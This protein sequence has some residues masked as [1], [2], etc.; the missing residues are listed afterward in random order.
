MHWAAKLNHVNMKY[1]ISSPKSKSIQRRSIS[2]E[3]LILI[4]TRCVHVFIHLI[5]SRSYHFP[6][7][8]EQARLD[9]PASRTAYVHVK[10][11]HKLSEHLPLQPCE[12][13]QRY[14]MYNMPLP[15]RSNLN[16]K[17]QKET[18]QPLQNRALR[19]LDGSQKAT[20]PKIQRYLRGLKWER[21]KEFMSRFFQSYLE[22]A[23]LGTFRRTGI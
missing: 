5:C 23:V 18:I 4:L 20:L 19:Y 1:D 3:I 13:K 22:V 10:G 8:T 11:S 15:C 12:S 9:H 17:S 16:P 14:Y 6:K 2:I 7:Y 21:K